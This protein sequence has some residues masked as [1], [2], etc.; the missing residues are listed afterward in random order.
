M[1]NYQ[2]KK[3]LLNKIKL[4]NNNQYNCLKKEKEKI[5]EEKKKLSKINKLKKKRKQSQKKS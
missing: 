4:N 5:D 2:V 3:Y 1:E